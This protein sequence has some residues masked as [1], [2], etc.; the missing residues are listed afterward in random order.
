MRIAAKKVRHGAAGGG[1]DGVGTLAGSKGAV[2]VGIAAAQI[3][4][5]GVDD[6]LR[7]LRPARP[8]EKDHG[9]SVEGLRQGRKLGADPGQIK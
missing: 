7:N 1:D 5:D 2:G 9:F 8:I 3:I 6:A 4:R